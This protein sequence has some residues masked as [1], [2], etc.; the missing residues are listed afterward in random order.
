LISFRR[1]VSQEENFLLTSPTDSNLSLH[2][3]LQMASSMVLPFKITQ[4]EVM[5]NRARKGSKIF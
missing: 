4:E 2:R 5:R 1:V 3:T